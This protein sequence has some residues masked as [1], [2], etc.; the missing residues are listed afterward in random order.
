MDTPRSNHLRD[1]SGGA[2]ASF[3]AT[4]LDG[5]V[6]AALSPLT[7]EQPAALAA[8]AACGA[9]AGGITHFTLCRRWVFRRFDAPL[10]HAAPRYV[11]M[12]ATSAALHAAFV[13]LATLWLL[14]SLA[15]LTSRVL[16][17]L[18]WTYPVSRYHVFSIHNQP[19]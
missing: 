9:A 8:C 11:L 2:L 4:A 16:I 12:S 19:S 1:L 6:F 14:P 3:I 15:W 17:Y 5:A 7:H 18:A 10:R 13:G